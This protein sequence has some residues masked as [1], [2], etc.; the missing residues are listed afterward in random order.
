MED[1]MWK[2]NLKEWIY[3]ESRIVT[4]K[5]LSKHLSVHVNIAKQMLFDFI[6]SHSH[7]KKH[8]ELE[9]IYL[10]AGRLASSPKSIKVCLVN[11]KDLAEKEKEFGSL[12]S[13]HV[14]AVSK[15]EC[16]VVNETNIC[17]VSNILSL[18]YI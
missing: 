13:K 7:D 9:V 3:D 8:S 16:S 14:Y 4:Y 18:S 15:S 11:G 5:W 10:L 12:T 2:E 17:Q 1:D 6:Q